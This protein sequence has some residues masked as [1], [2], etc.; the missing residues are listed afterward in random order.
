MT[1][2][3]ILQIKLFLILTA[4]NCYSAF[5]QVT[6]NNN[7]LEVQSTPNLS[8]VILPNIEDDDIDDL[9]KKAG[10]IFFHKDN[11]KGVVNTDDEDEDEDEDESVEVE[12]LTSTLKPPGYLGV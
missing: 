6:L 3:N 2:I 1:Y 11:I 8:G 12:T 9:D 5:A 10:L 7:G 4:L